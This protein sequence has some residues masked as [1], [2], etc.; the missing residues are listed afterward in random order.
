LAVR[1][2][3][4]VG[5]KT[6]SGV[7]MGID[8]GD[9]FS[10]YSVIGAT[11]S[12]LEEGRV[13]T[14]AEPLSTLLSGRARLRV[15]IETGTHSPWVS[16]LIT[17]KGHEPIVANARKVKLISRSKNKRDR[18]DALTL[19]RLGL[20]GRDLLAPV[21]HRS[22]QTQQRR[23]WLLSRDAAVRART[24]LINHVRGIVKSIGHRLPSCS[25]EAFPKQ[26]KP[27]LPGALD[28]T[29]SPL[30]AIVTSLTNTIRRYDHQIEALSRKH[31]PLAERL[32]QVPGVGPITALAYMLTI[33][34]PTRFRESRTVGA[35]LGLVPATHQS[36]EQMPQ[37]HITKEGDVLLRRLLVNAAQYILGRFGP[38]CDLRRYG[39]RIA[40]RGRKIAKKRAVVA[41]AR[42]LAVLL[43]K[44]WRDHVNY[45]P[46]YVTKLRTAAAA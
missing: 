45:D 26:A 38:D 3:I 37:M 13:A 35:Y 16:R 43:H 6:S 30:L 4:K 27:N 42:K 10:H 15:V 23:A 5:T 18:V 19:A 20:A 40:E 17:A 22:E 33:E 28:A 2:N 24:E 39:L 11:G 9:R 21:H 36:G 34:D 31:Y 8:I 7:V 12:L 44:L 25:A 1:K 46:L 32:Q 29:L 14:L 41:V